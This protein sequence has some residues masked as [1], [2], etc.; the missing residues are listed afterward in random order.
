MNLHQV[1]NLH[2]DS[3]FIF[4]VLNLRHQLSDVTKHD[5]IIIQRGRWKKR[6]SADCLHFAIF[7][8]SW[9]LAELLVS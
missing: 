3:L 9:L 5:V 6:E 4:S 2:R 8:I 1:L 7:S